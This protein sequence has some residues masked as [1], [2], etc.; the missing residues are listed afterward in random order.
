MNPLVTP[1][2][3]VLAGGVCLAEAQWIIGTREWPWSQYQRDAAARA[4]DDAV[5]VFGFSS[6]DEAKAY[7]CEPLV[8][9]RIMPAG[10]E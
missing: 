6:V 9:A 4:L 2:A 3:R 8:G 1:D 10:W 7:V 5:V